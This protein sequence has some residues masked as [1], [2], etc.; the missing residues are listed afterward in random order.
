MTGYVPEVAPL[1][2]QD[3]ER[4]ANNL[5]RWLCPD[6]L[7]KP[8]WFPVL[9]YWEALRDRFGLDTGVAELPDGVEGMTWPDGRVLVTE[10]TYRGV[11]RGEG[12]PRHTM[13]HEGYH[14][15]QH[16]SQIQR[17]LIH[18]GRLV[19]LRRGMPSLPAY[20]DPEWQAEAFA[21]AALMPADMV[22]SLATKMAPA[23]LV[24]EVMESFGVSRRSAE[25]RL[26]ILGVCG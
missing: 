25:V 7:R 26:R 22:R 21:G 1:S 11:V 8:G 14:G 4:Q 23:F 16:R 19:L 2:R 18:T 15:M 17:V 24:P 10:E 5:I 12:R 3:I 20:K 6:R 13:V 9:E